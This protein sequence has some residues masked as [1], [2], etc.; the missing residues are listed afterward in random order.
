MFERKVG[1]E[2]PV[3]LITIE[4]YLFLGAWLECKI[5]EVT[6]GLLLYIYKAAGA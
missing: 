5:A 4:G 6:L 2:N 3:D 1:F